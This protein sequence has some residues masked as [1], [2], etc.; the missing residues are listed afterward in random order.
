MEE[1]LFDE[2]FMCV[3]RVEN[4]LRHSLRLKTYLAAEHLVI[5]SPAS[6]EELVRKTV[7]PRASRR[8]VC[9]QVPHYMVTPFVLAQTHLLVVLPK[10][11]SADFTRLGVLVELPVPFAIPPVVTRRFW[12]KRSNHDPGCQ[13]L[14]TLI[15]RELGKAG[16]ARRSPHV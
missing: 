3:M 14:R 4:P 5:G 11:L 1:F 7:G 9:L 16:S 15:T 10:T 2:Y 12:H 6:S 13:W 8:R